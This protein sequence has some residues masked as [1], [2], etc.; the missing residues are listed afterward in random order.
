MYIFLKNPGLF[1]SAGSTSGIMDLSHSSNKYTSI[2]K[3][4]GD[5]DSN[6]HLFDMHSPV[7]LLQNITG[8]EKHLFFDCGSEDH[9]YESNNAFRKRCDE[10]KITATYISQPGKHEESYWIKSIQHHFEFFN[11]LI[12]Q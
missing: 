11:S 5:H 3:M 6:R 4:L 12:G 9:L 8:S 1:L 7:N 2:S 10:L